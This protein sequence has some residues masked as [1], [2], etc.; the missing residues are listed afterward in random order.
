M[1]LL[2]N[3]RVLVLWGIF[4][5]HAAHVMGQTEYIPQGGEY[6]VVPGLVGDQVNPAVSVNSSGGYL[7]WCD[8]ITDTNGYGVSALRLGANYSAAYSSFRVNEQQDGDQ[9]APSVTLLKDGGAA[10]VW[11]S[12]RQGFQKIYAR[13]ISSAGTWV[14]GE[15][16]V[17]TFTNNFQAGPVAATLT[18]GNVVVVWD[19][20]NQVSASSFRDVYSRQFTPAGQPVGGAEALVNQVT[21]YNQRTP[22]LAALSDGR[23]VVVWVT[24]QQRTENSVDIYGRIFSAPGVPAGAEFRVNVGTNICA[25]PSVTATSSGGF[26]VAWTERDS[27]IS[28]YS[29]EVVARSFSG[30]ATG[31]VV[32]KINT[33]S[34]GDQFAPRLSSAGS[35]CLAVWTSLAQDGS[36]EGV[37]GQFLNADASLNGS[38]F[39]V[40]STTAM[41][42]KFPAIASDGASRFLAVWSSYVG[43]VNSMDLF[44]QRYGTLLQPLLPPDPPYVNVLSSTSLALSWAAQAGLSV[45][46]YDV[47]A[48]G[49]VTPTVTVTNNWWT[50]TGLGAG[51]TNTFRIGYN[52]S[53]GRHSPLSAPA[54]GVTY[55]YPFTWSGIPYDWMAQ[56][57]GWDLGAWPSATLDSDGD[58]A[59]TAQEFLAGTDP[60]D[61]GSVLKLS[62]ADT[63]QGAFLTWNSEPGLVYQVQVSSNLGTWSNVGLPRV[64]AGTVDSMYVGGVSVAYYRVLRLR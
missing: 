17:N 33:H 51:T 41:G 64:A 63:P 55:L 12:G 1:S 25:N 21:A 48:N 31:G 14:T 6:G 60:L 19:S 54:T 62:M 29:L 49:S 27:L 50:M 32:R 39:R 3:A 23:Y 56:Y 9:N 44:A 8:N 59:T 52:L 26:M 61:A 37:Y 4:F 30:A 35:D 5:A 46:N 36:F 18:N 16:R 20:Y 58:G 47:Y 43:G 38:E 7:L 45:V 10:F 42:Q 34:Y 13:F 2:L 11:Q 15:Q 24:E 53:D 57:W 28:N 40:N 22:A